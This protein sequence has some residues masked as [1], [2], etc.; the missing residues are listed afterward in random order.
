MELAA[1]IAGVSIFG[2][3][4]CTI[5]LCIYQVVKEA[6]SKW[7]GWRRC[8]MRFNIVPI[9]TLVPGQM[10]WVE[11]LD[12]GTETQSR[13]RGEG[14]IEGRKLTVTEKLGEMMKV[15][16]ETGGAVRIGAMIAKSILVRQIA[17]NGVWQ[18]G[19]KDGKVRPAAGKE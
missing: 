12:C 2:L 13:L 10:G 3:G 6:Q 15:G 11:Y 9:S 1:I 19:I 17:P 16:V 7:Q 4:F 5:G 8:R 14:I 18:I